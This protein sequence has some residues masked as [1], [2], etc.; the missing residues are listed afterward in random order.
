MPSAKGIKE[1]EDYCTLVYDNS[2]LLKDS[3]NCHKVSSKHTTDQ[4]QMF[5]KRNYASEFKIPNP[6]HQSH[7]GKKP[8]KGSVIKCFVD[9]EKKY[10]FCIR[11]YEMIN[12]KENIYTVYI[13]EKNDFTLSYVFG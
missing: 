3:Q 8:T 4:L 9:G 1:K 12:K 7:G 11:R 2:L 6:F 13:G 10:V 5:E